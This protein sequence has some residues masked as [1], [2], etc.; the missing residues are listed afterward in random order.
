MH[1]EKETSWHILLEN[2]I[3]TFILT[4]ERRVVKLK[5]IVICILYSIKRKINYFI[6]INNLLEEMPNEYL[7]FWGG[8]I[9]VWFPCNRRPH[10]SLAFIKK[11]YLLGSRLNQFKIEVICV[12]LSN[13]NQIVIIVN[14]F[15]FP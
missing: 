8:G 7:F 10:V 1:T 3:L 15:F 5:G 12:G 13:N 9:S 6:V 11:C 2:N 4:Q 14:I